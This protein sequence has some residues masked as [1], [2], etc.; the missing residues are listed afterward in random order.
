MLQQ[1]ET[2]D[3]SS[4]HDIPAGPV[5]ISEMRPSMGRSVSSFLNVTPVTGA[6][7]TNDAEAFVRTLQVP[8][9]LWQ[10]HR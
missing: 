7:V 3:F 4:A 1:L 9:A 6:V 10:Y 8:S 5:D 2:H